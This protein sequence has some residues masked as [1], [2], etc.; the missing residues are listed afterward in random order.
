LV[1]RVSIG[2]FRTAAVKNHNFQVKYSATKPGT[3]TS[4]TVQQHSPLMSGTFTISLGGAPIK[5]LNST[6][7]KYTISDI[8]FNVEAYTLKQ[9]FRQI[10]GFE[11]VEV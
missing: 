4:T 8:P 10:I 7:G 11:N 3:F 9:A 2:K 1:W 5:I 6:T